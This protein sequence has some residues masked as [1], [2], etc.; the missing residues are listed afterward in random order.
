[1]AGD[2]LFLLDIRKGIE[3]IEFIIVPVVGITPGKRYGH[4]LTFCKPYIIVFGGNIGNSATNDVWILNVETSPFFWAK[5]ECSG[6]SPSQRV[7]HSS[8]LCNSG[9]ASRMLV[10]FGGRD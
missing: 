7:Y 4:T 3:N 2:E 6:P 5:I 10:T 1:M 8:A 9:F